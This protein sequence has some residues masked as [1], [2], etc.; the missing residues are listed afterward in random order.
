[1][2]FAGKKILLIGGT[3][4]LGKVLLRRLLELVND[5]PSK[6]IIFSRDEAKQ[7]DIRLA[8]TKNAFSTDEIIYSNFTQLVEFRIA[9]IRNYSDVCSALKEADIV[10]N[11]AALKQVPVCE[12]FP[13]QAIKTNCV[14]AYNIVRAL[15]E[16]D[17]P[18][19]VVIGASTDKAAKP[20]NAMGMTK[21]LQE[22]IFISA[23]ILNKATRFACVRYG[24]VLASR[25]SVI[26]LFHHQI[27]TGGPVTVTHPDMTRFLLSL[28][29]AADT[30]FKAI[31]EAKPGE[32]YVPRVASARIETIAR[33]LIEDRHIGISYTGV[34]PGEKMHEIL[35]SEEE[36]R[37]T[38]ARGDYYVIRPMLPELLEENEEFEGVL[39]KEYSSAD[40]LMDYEDTVRLLRDNRLKIGDI[41]FE[42]DKET[43]R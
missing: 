6:I 14:G 29:Q 5:A 37:H 13:M 31:E 1:M 35:I 17:Y 27:M 11:A 30:I 16:N 32:T 9:D 4:S 15:E 21:A 18:V 2:V 28:N 36:I 3:G 20:V 7:H 39:D 12:Y 10:I 22:R 26:P 33:A 41:D 23:N 34:R 25:G 19:E 43:L 40:H 8:N 42:Q 38:V 24:N